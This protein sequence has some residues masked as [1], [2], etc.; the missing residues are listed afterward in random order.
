M[1]AFSA[2]RAR[3]PWTALRRA[4]ALCLVAAAVLIALSPA[5]GTEAVPY[6]V[7]AVPLSAGA[8]LSP[9][10]VRVVRAPPDLRPDDALTDPA[11]VAG[12]VLTGA[13]ARGEPITGARLLDASGPGAAVPV[14]PADPAVAR[15]LRP[16][17]RVDVVPEPDPGAPPVAV[18][19]DVVVLTV[20]SGPDE[21]DAGPL[22]LLAVPP[23]TARLVAAATLRGPVAV[24]LR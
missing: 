15:L 16:G 24:T 1:S 17:A 23:E 12:R 2:L 20:R 9:T 13:A 19:E 11:E 6:L 4:A 10:D 5:D 18:A 8:A 21:D 14:R 7:S 3:L 22:V